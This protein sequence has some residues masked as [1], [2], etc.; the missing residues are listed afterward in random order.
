MAGNA[1]GEEVI[2]RPELQVKGFWHCPSQPR[3]LLR[4]CPLY[5]DS[6][7]DALEPRKLSRIVR[8]VPDQYSVGLKNELVV[9]L[10]Y[11]LQQIEQVLLA[12]GRFVAA[13]SQLPVAE[14]P[15][16]RRE[17]LKNFQGRVEATY[18]SGAVTGRPAPAEDAPQVATAAVSARY[19]AIPPPR[20]GCAIVP[21]EQALGHEPLS[22][23]TQLQGVVGHLP[24]E[25]M[26]WRSILFFDVEGGALSKVQPLALNCDG[27]PLN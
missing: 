4:V 3:E 2:Q 12:D 21:S 7:M 11:E 18:L 15:R 1:R 14:S 8:I 23:F 5:G 17:A 26:R 16:A 22:L 9:C 25:L 19:P 10:V 13:D 27:G 24:Q 6:D 20:S